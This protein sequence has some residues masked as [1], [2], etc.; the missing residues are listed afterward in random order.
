MVGLC[1]MVACNF[2]ASKLCKCDSSARSALNYRA[3][4]RH[5][6]LGGVPGKV[7]ITRPLCSFPT[8]TAQQAMWPQIA[9]LCTS[10]GCLS[11]LHTPFL[12]IAL[13]PV[14]LSLAGILVSCPCPVS[15]CIERLF[16][17]AIA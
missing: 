2:N 13:F 7:L 3:N 9:G 11:Q 5:D 14:G 1:T 17:V 10:V 16:C 12:Q 4:C 8:E 6:I 15:L